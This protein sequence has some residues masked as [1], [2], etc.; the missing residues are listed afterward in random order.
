MTKVGVTEVSVAEVGVTEVGVVEGILLGV[1]D[2][3]TT[4]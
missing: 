3:H 1:V 2:M 4:T